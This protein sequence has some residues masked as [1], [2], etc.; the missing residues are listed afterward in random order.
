MIMEKFIPIDQNPGLIRDI[1][2]KGVINV[3]DAQYNQF[4]K[5][6]QIKEVENNSIKKIENDI[7]CLK[8]DLCFIKKLITDLYNK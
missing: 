3:N 7:D 6:K 5:T 2:N 1:S 8:D 4:L